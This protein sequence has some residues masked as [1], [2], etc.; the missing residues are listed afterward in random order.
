MGS[1]VPINSLSSCSVEQSGAQEHA[2]SRPV[3]G[4]I[5]EG[6]VY[7]SSDEDD[8]DCDC[9]VCLADIRRQKGLLG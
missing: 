3:L 8:Y 1:V 5:A 7:V 9:V 4:D 6:N 2:L